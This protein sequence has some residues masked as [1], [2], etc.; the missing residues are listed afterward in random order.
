MKY[1]NLSKQ[2][3]FIAITVL[4]LAACSKVKIAEPMGDAGN[5]IIKIV[6]GGTPA[7]KLWSVDFVNTP[8][9]L[10]AIE[11]RRD[12]PN[13]TELNKS[14]TVVIKDDTAAVR[15]F[16]P[17][18]IQMPVAFYTT[19]TA[20]AGGQGGTYTL[21]FAP[22]EFAKEIYLTIPNATLMSTSSTYGLGFTLLTATGGKTS[23]AFKTLIY[24]IG[25]KNAYD[26]V[27]EC[28]FTNYHPTANPGYTGDV[29]E[30]EL[31][32]T[33]ANSCK[34]Y[35]PDAGAYACPAVLNGGLSYFGAQEPEYTVNPAT[36]IVTVQNAYVGATTFYTMSPVYSNLY[37]PSTKIM[38][39]KWGYNY[40]GGAFDA[41]TSR[42][43]TQKLTY[44]RPR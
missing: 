16:D 5:T 44:L 31:I 25:A 2:V 19:S 7:S 6:N 29:T 39:V 15:A 30:V 34:M 32:T 1:Y 40:V 12:A 43:W 4:V 21:T 41:S 28:N 33:G 36:N 18:L 37:D 10:L 26:G 22:G 27:Y 8:S 35:W 13:E 14:V 23:N 38:N 20:K 3:L 11:V 24:K 17:T 9:T 42:E